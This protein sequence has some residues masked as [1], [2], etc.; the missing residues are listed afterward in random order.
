MIWAAEGCK[1]EMSPSL[2]LDPWFQGQNSHFFPKSVLKS[3]SEEVKN[4]TQSPHF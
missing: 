1:L 4:S 2:A 3:N